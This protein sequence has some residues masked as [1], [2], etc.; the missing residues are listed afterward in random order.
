MSSIKSRW[1]TSCNKYLSQLQ[2]LFQYNLLND[3]LLTSWFGIEQEYIILDKNGDAFDIDNVGDKIIYN[4]NQHYC[5]VGT[6]KAMGRKIVDEHMLLCLDA[7][8]KICGTNAE[9]TASQ[10]EFQIGPL[11]ALDVS[12]QLWI[13]RYILIKVAEKY[14]ANITFHRY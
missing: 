1:N 4:H 6:G 14:N 7:G 5:S 3:E 11:N 13:A 10:W 8:I 12:A 9:V 2:K